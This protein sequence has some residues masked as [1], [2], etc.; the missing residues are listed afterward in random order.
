MLKTFR[1]HPQNQL[2]VQKGVSRLG[3]E[4]HPLTS[5]DK[6][7]LLRIVKGDTSMF[8]SFSS[9]PHR[10][11]QALKIVYRLGLEA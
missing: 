5:I 2:Q 11:L 7:V 3:L 10:K 4:A 8:R 9:H 6:K 1:S